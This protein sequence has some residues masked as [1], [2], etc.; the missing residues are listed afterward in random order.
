M[1]SLYLLSTAGC[2][3]CDTAAHILN[4]RHIEFELVEIIDDDQLVAQYG[5]KIPVLI[6]QGAEQAL[7]WPFDASQITQYKEYY[8]IS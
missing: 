7:F 6:A 4:D 2:H 3:L 8:G 5:D 1:A